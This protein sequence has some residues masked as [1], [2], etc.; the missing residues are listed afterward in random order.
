LGVESD[1]GAGGHF[2]RFLRGQ[3]VLRD[4]AEPVMGIAR[5][6]VAERSMT[7]RVCANKG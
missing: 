5:P 7:P 6:I 4:I 3:E 1:G 2:D